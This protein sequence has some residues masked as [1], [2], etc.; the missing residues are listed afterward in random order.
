MSNNQTEAQ[1]CPVSE[2]VSDECST[3]DLLHKLQAQQLELEMQNEALR[4]SYCIMEESRN[5]YRDLY[6]YSPLGY[7]RLTLDGLISEI[8]LTA[9]ELLGVEH[10]QLLHRHFA[11]LITPKDSDRWSL[12]S[13]EIVKNNQRL[14]I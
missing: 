2:T 12:F 1:P 6:H 5:R 11:N 13:G 9:A 14:G 10:S 8:N 4:R 3:Q 7:L